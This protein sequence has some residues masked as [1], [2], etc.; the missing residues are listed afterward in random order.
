[1]RKYITGLMLMGTGLLF[2]GAAP[3]ASLIGETGAP[4]P[5]VAG[6]SSDQAMAA[7]LLAGNRREIAQARA[8]INHAED[9]DVRAFAQRL[10][11]EH[12]R[13]LEKLQP[14]AKRLGAVITDSAAANAGPTPRDDLSFVE[15][16]ADGHRQLLDHLKESKN[17]IRDD[18]LRKFTAEL[19][20]AVKGHLTR[21][22]QLQ[23]RL[24]PST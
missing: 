12:S 24:K 20:L 2:T 18:D 22:Q 5:R 7:E 21:A 6:D 23:A 1:M 15:A 10:D 9:G 17:G 11:D 13:L 8:Y 16:Q 3:P 4:A 14:I 19:Q